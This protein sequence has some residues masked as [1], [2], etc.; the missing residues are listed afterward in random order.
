MKN[1]SWY[2]IHFP[3]ILHGVIFK[4]ARLIPSNPP[5]FFS[6]SVRNISSLQRKKSIGSQIGIYVDKITNN[7]MNVIS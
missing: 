3:F 1:L 4:S 7:R 5:P 6:S 2:L